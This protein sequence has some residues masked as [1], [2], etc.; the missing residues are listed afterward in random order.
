MIYVSSVKN[1]KKQSTI[2]FQ[3]NSYGEE[4]NVNWK[5]IYGNNME[6][7]VLIG[8]FIKTRRGRPR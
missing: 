6:E 7:Q 1:S 4:P 5:L 8:T 2:F 3:Y